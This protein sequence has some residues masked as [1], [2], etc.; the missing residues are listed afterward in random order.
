MPLLHLHQQSFQ[1]LNNKGNS[2][3]TQMYVLFTIKS[4]I[5]IKSHFSYYLWRDW[6]IDLTESAFHSQDSNCVTSHFRFTGNDACTYSTWCVTQ[7]TLPVIWKIMSS[8]SYIYHRCS[9]SFQHTVWVCYKQMHKLFLLCCIFDSLSRCVCFPQRL[10][11]VSFQTELWD[12]LL[13]HTNSYHQ[14]PQMSTVQTGTEV[15]RIIKE[16]VI[17][18]DLPQPFLSTVTV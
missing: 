2:N 11:Q 10:T 3:A 5:C 13:K 9:E 7:E 14:Q 16:I 1:N 6:E 15:W 4:K 17:P 12:L 8:V 18:R